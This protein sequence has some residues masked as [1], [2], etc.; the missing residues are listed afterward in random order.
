LA[1]YGLTQEGDNT[2][3]GDSSPWFVVKPRKPSNLQSHS[4]WKK[5]KILG[6]SCVI[7]QLAR[8]NF[9]GKIYKNLPL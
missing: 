9:L 8:V 2:S 7:K 1:T 6:I 4:S 5:L 3:V